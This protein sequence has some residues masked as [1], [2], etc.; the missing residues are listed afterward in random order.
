MTSV[1]QVT[2]VN[3]A[4]GAGKFGFSTNRLVLNTAIDYDTAT[5]ER[6]NTVVTTVTDGGP[7]TAKTATFTSTVSIL[8]VNE[9]TPAI[10][11][12]SSVT[13][14]EN[15]AADTTVATLTGNLQS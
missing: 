13:V 15:T 12:V 1:L 7:G 4:A 10:A 11:A 14:A 2:H 3:G 8:P 6:V 9:A 5:A